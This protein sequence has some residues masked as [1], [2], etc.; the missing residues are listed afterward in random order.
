MTKV[1]LEIPDNE[2]EFFTTVANKFNYLIEIEDE[3]EEIPIEVQNLIHQR[4]LTTK[5]EEIKDW[6]SFRLQIK[7]EY[8]L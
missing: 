1:T 8:G 6:S 2:V 5:P 4:R 3:F 7:E